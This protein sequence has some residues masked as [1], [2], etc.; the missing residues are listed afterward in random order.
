MSEY[1]TEGSKPIPICPMGRK[2]DLPEGDGG[3][4]M[5]ASKLSPVGMRPIKSDGAVDYSKMLVTSLLKSL[6]PPPKPT[7]LRRISYEVKRGLKWMFGWSARRRESQRKKRMA[8][9]A[10]RM[11][12]V[13][14]DTFV[15]IKEDSRNP[16]FDPETYEMEWKEMIRKAGHKD[17]PVVLEVPGGESVIGGSK[18]SVGLL[19][20][21]TEDSAGVLMNSNKARLRYLLG[22]DVLDAEEQAELKTLTDISGDVVVLE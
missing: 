17:D 2:K 7:G 5:D 9:L 14:L 21:A 8:R 3:E 10:S 13:F 12:E 18:E 22:K 6:T 19:R 16:Y 4:R 15:A 1:A 11:S 20:V